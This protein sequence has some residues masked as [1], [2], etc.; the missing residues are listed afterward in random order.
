MDSCPKEF[1]PSQ[2]LLKR[3]NKFVFKFQIYAQ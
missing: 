2:N 3:Q 1:K